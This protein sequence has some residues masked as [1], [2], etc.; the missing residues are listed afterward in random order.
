MTMCWLTLPPSLIP[1][2][3]PFVITHLPLHGTKKEA[4]PQWAQLHISSN[5]LQFTSITSDTRTN[6]II[7]QA[8]PMLWQMIVVDYGTYQ[9]K[10]TS[11]FNSNYPQKESL[12]MHHLCPELKSTL[13]SSLLKGQL[14]PE[15]YLPATPKPKRFGINGFRFAPSS[16]SNRIF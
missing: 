4:L 2:P 5:S 15:L 1:L 10:I 8:L 16:M 11:Y 6:Y 7:L 9:T 14:Q 13:I 12:K 3:A